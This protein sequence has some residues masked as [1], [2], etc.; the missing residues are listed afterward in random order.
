MRVISNLW[1]K[2][3]PGDPLHAETIAGAVLL[4][5]FNIGFPASLFQK[6][7]YI[8]AWPVMPAA[9]STH[10]DEDGGG[11]CGLVHLDHGQDLRH[12]SVDRPGVEEPG[13]R[14]E[15]PVDAAEAGHGHGHGDDEGHVAVQTAPERLEDQWIERWARNT[16]TTNSPLG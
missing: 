7:Q 2:Q 1:C 6:S 16:T 12:L 3:T 8:F 5:V 15:D 9:G 13:G 4:Y 14:Q 11:R 10:H